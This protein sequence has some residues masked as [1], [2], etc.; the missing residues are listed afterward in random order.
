MPPLL[1]AFCANLEPGRDGAQLEETAQVHQ[2]AQFALVEFSIVYNKLVVP[3]C[4]QFRMPNNVILHAHH[5]FGIFILGSRV[6]HDG[7]VALHDVKH[8]QGEGFPPDYHFRILNKRSS[9]S[10][11]ETDVAWICSCEPD[12]LVWNVSPWWPTIAKTFAFFDTILG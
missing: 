12:G 10:L 5:V 4:V 1:P 6:A 7:R 11:W 2:T 3:L 8:G 9:C